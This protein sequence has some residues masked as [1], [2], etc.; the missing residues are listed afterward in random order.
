MRFEGTLKS[1]N[2]DRGFGFIEP[3]QGGQEIFV[4]ISAFPRDGSSPKIGE[5]LS[6]GIDHNHDGKKR[7]AN[8]SRPG[9]SVPLPRRTAAS[10]SGGWRG[11]ASGAVT[12]AL[13]IGIGAYGYGKFTDYK[14]GRP[15]PEDASAEIGKAEPELSPA[16]TDLRCDGRTHCSQMTSCAEATFFLKNCPGAQ[17]DGNHD[18]V[19]CE[20]QW[21]PGTFSE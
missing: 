17:M 7:A 9:A 1:W 6:F 2:E 5:R 20:Q 11:T 21:C 4:H 18:G 19:P 14:T 16:A 12:L 15:L 8:V 3:A 13:L 10:R